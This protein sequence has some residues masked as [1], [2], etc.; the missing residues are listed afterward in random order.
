MVV[1][2]AVGLLDGIPV[3]EA[4]GEAVGASQQSRLDPPSDGQQ[5]PFN[6]RL[7]HFGL[8]VQL[9]SMKQQDKNV[10]VPSGWVFGQQ[11]PIRSPHC[12]LAAHARGMAL[13]RRCINASKESASLCLVPRRMLWEEH[14][15]FETNKA[16]KAEKEA[17]VKNM[18]SIA[19]LDG[20][21]LEYFNLQIVLVGP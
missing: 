10:S 4:V 5:C 3:G 19:R 13:S 21:L 2:L 6:P 16:S 15:L 18:L 17:L 1:G 9:S 8:S 14:G 12:G 20:L 7:L 11:S